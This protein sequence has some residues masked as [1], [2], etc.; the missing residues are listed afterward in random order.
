MILKRRI[1]ISSIIGILVIIGSG[2]AWTEIYGGRHEALR[3]LSGVAVVA[4]LVPTGSNDGTI[5]CTAIASAVKARLKSSG[6]RVMTFDEAA[7]SDARSFVFVRCSAIP[8]K[9]ANGN[10]IGYTFA[11]MFLMK[12]DVMLKHDPK[13][14][15]HAV[16]WDD[17]RYGITAGANL[18]KTV[19][20][21]ALQMTDKFSEDFLRANPRK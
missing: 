13:L 19:S 7:K 6:V 10:K 4:E 20:D 2:I 9:T 11:V 3:N 14:C 12:Q 5:D 17:A 1:L 15:C 18:T 21:C 8:A 16:T